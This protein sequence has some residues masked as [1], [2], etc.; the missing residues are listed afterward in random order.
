MR[1]LVFVV[2]AFLLAGP[3]LAGEA[4]D[5]ALKVGDNAVQVPVGKFFLVR[6]GTKH[7]AIKLTKPITKG[8]GGFEY[9]WYLREG[10]SGGFSNEKA[11]KGKGE[12]FEKYLRTPKGDGSFEVRDDGGRLEIECKSLSVVWS[13]SNWIYFASPRGEVEIAVTNTSDIKAVDCSDKK[14]VWHSR[15]TKIDSQQPVPREVF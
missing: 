13:M 1:N 11:A 9:V 10:G 15:K 6:M 7:A 4:K 12:V 14:L 8:D 2:H 3:L 5:P